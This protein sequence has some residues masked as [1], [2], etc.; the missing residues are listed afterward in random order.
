MAPPDMHPSQ[1]HASSYSS[2]PY[3]ASATDTI[4]QPH[5][6]PA[7]PH[8]VAIITNPQ[9]EQSPPASD[10]AFYPTYPE[11]YDASGMD[12]TAAGRATD[13]PPPVASATNKVDVANSAGWDYSMFDVKMPYPPLSPEAVQG[14]GNVPNPQGPWNYGT[15]VYPALIESTFG[16]TLGIASSMSQYVSVEPSMADSMSLRVAGKESTNGWYDSLGWLQPPPMGQI[17]PSPSQ[18]SYHTSSPASGAGPHYSRHN[19]CSSLPA[20]MVAALDQ[21]RFDARFQPYADQAVSPGEERLTPGGWGKGAGSFF[22]GDTNTA[23]SSHPASQSPRNPSYQRTSKTIGSKRKSPLPAQQTIKQEQDEADVRPP[24]KQQQHQQKKSEIGSQA[25]AKVESQTIKPMVRHRNRDAAN[26]CRAKTK[27]A[28][29]NLESTER[30]MSAEHRDLS[31]TARGLRDEVLMLK[32]ELL[33][34]GSCDDALIQRY[35]MNQARRFGY[36]TEAE[37]QQRGQQQHQQPPATAAAAS[38]AVLE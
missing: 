12:Y 2:S 8:R 11:L 28:V 35:L 26:K 17:S 4:S 32:T 29:A 3:K 38:P 37:A 7:D 5:A 25:Q 27:R 20:A 23:M 13:Q 33:A 6:G 9:H 18:S 19:S 16:D 1:G 14:G 10:G 34:H 21:N 24:G 36:D 15:Q 30:A 22:P 31:A